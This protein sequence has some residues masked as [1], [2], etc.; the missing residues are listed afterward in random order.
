LVNKNLSF[1]NHSIESVDEN[2]AFFTDRQFH[3][4]K[5]AREIYYALGTPS[6]RDFK[7]II[8]SNQIRN[9][10]INIE[11]VTIAEKV[12]GPDIGSLKGKPTRQKSDPVVSD[13]IEIPE[14]LITNHNNA[15][16]CIDG[17]KINGVPF[18]TT[19]LHNIMY[20][21][22]EWIPSQTSKAYRSVLDNIFSVYNKAGIK[23]T[24]IHCDNK[25]R[26]LMQELHD[27]YE[28]TMN[29]ANP[30]E[31]IPEAERNN[32]VIKERFRASFH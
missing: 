2:K 17:M 20:R 21:T 15:V 1:L 30:Q 7:M 16:L 28:V 22:A 8:T 11:D 25:F 31:H 13:Y 4:A 29:Y 23:I 32:C 10:P 5:H 3:R 14:E 26:P 19:I 6:L 24:T 12:F 18:L 9:L 27:V